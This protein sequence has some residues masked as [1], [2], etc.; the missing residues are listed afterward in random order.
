LK[1]PFYT[2]LSFKISWNLKVVD[3]VKD[4]NH[5]KYE[6]EKHFL[7][8]VFLNAHINIKL[9]FFVTGLGTQPQSSFN[10]SGKN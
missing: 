10:Y 9:A 8:E 6:V 2:F 5:H 4:F 3:R 1:N 7:F